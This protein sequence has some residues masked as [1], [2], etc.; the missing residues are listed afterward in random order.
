MTNMWGNEPR[1]PSNRAFTLYEIMIELGESCLILEI[2]TLHKGPNIN[3]L[4]GHWQFM[5]NSSD[6]SHISSFLNK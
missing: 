3:K 5:A 1:S 2:N 4:N 6:F